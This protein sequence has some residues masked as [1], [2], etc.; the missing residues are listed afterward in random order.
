M[1]EFDASSLNFAN[2]LLAGLA[3]LV[4]TIYLARRKINIAYIGIPMVFMIFMTGWAM[5]LNIQKFYNTSKWLLLGIGLAVFI[6]EIWMIIES[7][8]VFKSVYGEE[9][10]AVPETR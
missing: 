3:L 10:G 8:I 1:H 5:I 7:A 4:T 2:R 6:L 9:G